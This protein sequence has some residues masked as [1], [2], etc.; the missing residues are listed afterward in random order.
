MDVIESQRRRRRAAALELEN[1]TNDT[2]NI[3]PQLLGHDESVTANHPKSPLG[4]QNQSRDNITTEDASVHPPSSPLSDLDMNCEDTG[5]ALSPVQNHGTN[6]N[7][8]GGQR[9]RPA[10]ESEGSHKVTK[11]PK[12]VKRRVTRA[13][14]K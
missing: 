14:N 5:A 7:G 11:K 6:L 1:A 3:D 8:R 4:D 13:Q 12:A 9:K 10:G 2:S